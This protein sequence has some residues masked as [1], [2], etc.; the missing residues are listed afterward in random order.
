LSFIGK[1][2]EARRNYLGKITRGIK[3]F[4]GSGGSKV[5]FLLPNPE[6]GEKK[7]VTSFTG[8]DDSKEREGIKIS[9]EGLP[10][11]N[12]KKS[13]EEVTRMAQRGVGQ[14]TGGHNN[15]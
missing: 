9:G 12:Q 8:V 14:V 5:T 2:K 11:K 13:N 6:G 1:Y 4:R 7:I 15:S 10:K 3:L